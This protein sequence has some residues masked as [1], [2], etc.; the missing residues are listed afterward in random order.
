LD[1]TSQQRTGTV[2][3]RV[4]RQIISGAAAAALC[5]A[6]GGTAR[7][8][9]PLA[10]RQ[11]PGVHRMR[12][13]TFEVTAL[14][15]GYQNTDPRVL[16]IDPELLGVLL[17]AAQLPAGPIQIAVNA[18]AINTGE[19]LLLIDCGAGTSL[20]PTLGRLPQA[21]TLAGID[22]AQVDEVLLTHAHPD[23]IG[24]MI[25]AQG[26][27][28]FPN[29][30]LRLAEQ[31]LAYWSSAENEARESARKIRYVVFKRVLSAYAGRVRAFAAGETIAPGVQ[32]LPAPGHTAGHSLY[33][34]ESQG[35][36]LLAIGDTLHINAV[37]FS[38][39]EVTIAY[40]TDTAQARA[41]RRFVLDR[42]ASEQLL[43]A[44]AHL[45]FP[46]IGHVR[47]EGASYAFMPIPW[48]IY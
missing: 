11:V 48:Q 40:D 4:R 16:A 12:L 32:S 30:T 23:H 20:G 36:R 34:I 47:R 3:D 13:G 15:D 28:L 18:F 42:A 27:A 37:Q 45:P 9:A 31:D 6:L 5:P 38:R 43:I 24:G 26:D 1:D 39:P 22:P 25:G 46:G 29:A 41:T 2:P 33:M 44:A 8:A 7:A 10:G 17:A 35:A 19:R 21:M 14:L